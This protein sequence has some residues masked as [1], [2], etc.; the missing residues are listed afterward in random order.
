MA[1][2]SV[3]I[4]EKNSVAQAFAGALKKNFSRRDGYLESDDAI[5]TWCV[6]HLV[7]MSYPEVY[8]EKFAKWSFDTLPFIPENYRYE[9]IRNVSKQFNI[10]KGLLNRDD[11]DTIYICTDSGREGEYIYRLVDMQ[12]N[13]KGKVRKRVWIDSQT[14]EEI[15]RG[16]R[17]AKDDSEYDNLGASAF[18]RAKEDYL[19]GI[20]FSRALTLR[21][22]YSIKNY[23]GLDK[24]VI[25]VGRVMTCVLGIVVDREREIRNFVKT[26]FYRVLAGAMIN[27][28]K[29][30]A[31]WRVTQDSHFDGSPELYSEK[32][33]KA[34]E[35]AE[36]LIREVGT[37]DRSA[38]VEKCETK[39]EVK[40]PPLLYNLAELQNDC[41][42]LFKI[43]PDETLAIAQELYEKKLTTYPRTDAR[44]MSSAIAKV[45]DQNI[46]GL[47]AYEPCSV[48]AR[49]ILQHESYK[50]IAKTRYVND[51][52]ITDHYAIIPTGQGFSAISSLSPT[53]ALVYEII[54]RRFLAVFYPPATY[55]KVG[56]ELSLPNLDNEGKREHFFA[57]FKIL[58]GKGY[59]HVMDYS[60]SKKKDNKDSE[61]EAPKDGE[62]AE[63]TV[64]DEE[65]FEYLKKI[66]KGDELPIESFEIKEGETSPPKRYSSGT[67][68]L[69]MENAGQFIEDEELRAQIKGSGIGTSATR[70]GILTKLFNI[71]YLNLNKKTQIITP[72][73]MGEMVYETVLC[74]MKPMLN[75]ALTASW[76]K[77]LTGVA[78][79]SI[80]EQEYLNK[81]NDFVT[82][83]TNM[84]KQNDYRNAL[85]SRFDY[86][87]PFYKTTKEKKNGRTQ[88][89]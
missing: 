26:P 24:C 15:L 52:A 10:V 17:E 20:N 25:S 85:R 21:Y 65:L 77:G 55:Q 60:F 84:V 69:T 75:P 11:V 67:I 18:L 22:A 78:D 70:A 41:S 43:N 1:N 13:V 79:G 46:K 16:I 38:T 88:K 5:V 14:E 36:K 73:Q 57:N 45:I 23:L 32:G 12:A 56:L 6:G 49:A 48:F 30:D 59:L 37:R 42:R 53:S 81:L 68:I 63:Q 19:M 40:N 33:F 74:S 64:T 80:S 28:K 50:G 66:K 72:T 2:K 89:K 76:E 86:V 62:D 87:A 9:V 82:K 7:T 27:G 39:K 3:Y 44:V 35:G 31:E 34:K 54:V 58:T 61:E 47:T 71:G 8:D 51:K 83:R 4:A 29:C